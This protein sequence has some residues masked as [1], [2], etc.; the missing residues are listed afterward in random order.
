M[1][2][3]AIFFAPDEPLPPPASSRRE[4]AWPAFD[5]L[6]ADHPD[7]KGLRFESFFHGLTA[8]DHSTGFSRGIQPVLEDLGLWDTPA[9]KEAH[10]LWFFDGAL[11]LIEPYPMACETIE[12]LRADY[13]LGLITNGE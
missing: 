9:G 3:R 1:S 5:R 4:R 13:T 6:K 10:G 11:D 2:L 7:H 12:A 8:Y